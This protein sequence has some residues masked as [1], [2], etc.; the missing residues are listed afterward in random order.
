MLPPENNKTNN[1]DDRELDIKH[2]LMV[3]LRHKW[4]ILLSLLCTIAGTLVYLKQATPMYKTSVKI[5]IGDERGELSLFKELDFL[6]QARMAEELETHCELLKTHQL[7]RNVVV[8]LGLHKPIE[9]EPESDPIISRIKN[10]IPFIGN[11]EDEQKA[12]DETEEIEKEVLIRKSTEYLQEIIDVAPIN[13][14][15]VIQVTV[16]N[17]DPELAASI[18]NELA[19]VFIEYDL[20]NMIWEAK[21]AHDFIKDQLKVVEEKLRKTEEQLKAFKEEEEVVEL[22]EEAKITLEKLSVVE[23]NYSTTLAKIQEA[24][25]RLESIKKE[26]ASQSETIKTSTTVSENPL[27][28]QLKGQLYNLEIEL[29]GLQK[30]YSENSPEVQQVMTKINESKEKLAQEVQKTVSSEISAVN[31]VHQTLVGR[32]IELQADVIAYEIMA[33]A[34]KTFVDQYRTELDKLPSK[35]LQLARLM[36]DK[37]VSDQIYMMLMQRSEEA[38]LAQ[39]IQVGNISIADPAMVPLRPYSP[40]R[41]LY[42]MMGVALGMMLGLGLAFLLE[43]MDTSLKNEDEV[44]KYIELPLLGALPLIRSKPIYRPVRRNADISLTRDE[45]KAVAVSGSVKLSKHE[46]KM[47]TNVSPKAPEAETYRILITNIQFSEVDNPIK[48]M[49]LTSSTPGEGKTITAINLAI[50][51]ARSGKKTLLIDADMRK[52]MVHKLFQLNRIPGLSDLLLDKASLDEITHSS[53]VENLF[54]ISAGTS[55][56]N[57]PQLLNSQKMEAFIQ[58]VQN[59]YDMVIFDTPPATVVTDPAILGSKLDAVCLV[60]EAERTNRDLVIR[61]KELLTTV[62]ARVLGVILNKIDVT[63][64][65]G[66]YDYTY[67]YYYAEEPEKKKKARKRK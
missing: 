6:S 48:T 38:Q 27:L 33:D 18:A 39:A 15:R 47:L 13:N 10:S 60:V 11:N 22:T 35:E 9:T 41:K 54:L 65:Y 62:D 14:T 29:A 25:A 31:P 40:K 16:A 26:L 53:H 63:K 3:I 28:Q 5:L 67:Y 36:R 51:M 32:L 8:N 42:L 46:S 1:S 64:G 43:Y 58:H 21:S 20:E 34:Q 50:M 66:S 23:T 55:P 61:A 2:Y 52:P 49:M 19:R 59:Y 4:I 57:A 30:V 12:G 24:K 37:N 56:P 7:A 45:S 44:R 17:T